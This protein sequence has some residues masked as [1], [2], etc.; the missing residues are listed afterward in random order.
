MARITIPDLYCPL[1]P[2][3]SQHAEDAESGLLD[4]ATRIGLIRDRD[5]LVLSRNQLGHLSGYVHPQASKE[6]VVI[7]AAWAAWLYAYDDALVE[8]VSLGSPD[9]VHRTGLQARIMAALEDCGEP[10]FADPLVTAI[11]DIRSAVFRVYP[12]WDTTAFVRD[13]RKYLESNHWEIADRPRGCPPRLGVYVKMR[14]HTSAYYPCYRL[15]AALS[16]VNLPP[17]IWNHV[18]VKQLE[19]MANNYG[20]WLNDLYS[21]ERE[22]AEGK[23]NGLVQSLRQEYGL[24]IAEAVARTSAMCRSEIEA[25]FELKSLLPAMG[26][27]VTGELQRYLYV[28]ESWMRG[29]LDWHRMTPRYRPVHPG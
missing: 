21:F 1:P 16:R 22:R 15:S 27:P 7:G 20:S 24:D 14:R 2:A 13:L 28:L 9:D 23:S 26:L 10:A 25:Y 19:A 5:T 6:E 12:S 11:L 17:H 3:L 18:A 29:I 8:S 4:W